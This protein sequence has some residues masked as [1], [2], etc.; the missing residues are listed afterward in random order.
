VSNAGAVCTTPSNPPE[1]DLA[2]QQLLVGG[3]MLATARALSVA[4]GRPAL[5]RCSVYP[6]CRRR[7]A[8]DMMIDGVFFP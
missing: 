2:R 8:G 4:G 5:S 6:P 3:G 7:R 1:A